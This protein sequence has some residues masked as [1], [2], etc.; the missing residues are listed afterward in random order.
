D[1]ERGEHADGGDGDAVD[2]AAVA[3]GPVTGEVGGAD[4]DHDGDHREGGGPHALGDA[5]DD[6]G[7]GTGLG[8]AGNLL[9]GLVGVGGEPLGDL[10]D[11]PADDQAGDDGDPD[12]HPVV[13]LVAEDPVGQPGDADGR[14]DHGEVG[15][16][17]ERR[18]QVVGVLR[19]DQEGAHDGGQHAEG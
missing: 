1:A 4:A 13:D 14:G 2:A 18:R 19:L 8:L 6:Q 3:H 12:A 7:G 11:E 15:A 9:D 16:P 17:V 10:A 5:G